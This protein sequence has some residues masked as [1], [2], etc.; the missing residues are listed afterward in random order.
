MAKVISKVYGDALFSLALENDKLDTIWE[1]VRMTRQILSENPTFVKTICHP[2]IT[3]QDQIKL[4][5]DAFKGK[6]SDEVMGFFHVLADKKRLKEL[7][8]VLEYFDR[9]AKE[10]KKIGVVYVTVPMELTKAQQDKIRERI[11]EV[12]SYETLEMHVETDASL[13]GG[14][15]IR[16]GDEILDNSIR[17]KMEHMARKIN[18]I[19]LSS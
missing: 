3:K 15:V 6:V 5:D 7:D 16:I 4:L 9:S 19:K 14:M 13:L 17:S 12:S 18:Q 8:A 1:E 11:L 10:Y 2:E